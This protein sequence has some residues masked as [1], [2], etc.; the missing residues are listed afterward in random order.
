MGT[1]RRV[2]GNR[3]AGRS[4]CVA[5]LP[6]FVLDIH[7]MKDAALAEHLRDVVLSAERY[8][9]LGAEPLH[10]L[11][12]DAVSRWPRS[13][14]PSTTK[15]VQLCAPQTLTPLD[16]IPSKTGC[17]SIGEVP[18]TRDLAGRR[19]TPSSPPGLSPGR[20]RWSLLSWGLTDEG[21]LGFRLHLT[22]LHGDPSVSLCLPQRRIDDSLE[23]PRFGGR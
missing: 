20:G 15:S 2:P 21:S 3:Q 16:A 23:L 11:R 10:S 19:L 6:G 13:M 9:E 12:G 17:V 7:E 5:A 14:S 4:R 8:G 18:M 22:A 1:M